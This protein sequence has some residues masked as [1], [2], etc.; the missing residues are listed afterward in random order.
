[1]AAYFGVTPKNS[2]ALVFHV[3]SYSTAQRYRLQN[4]GRVRRLI[5]HHVSVKFALYERTTRM[6]YALDEKSSS[7][8]ETCALILL[9][10]AFCQRRFHPVILSLAQASH[11]IVFPTHSLLSA[12]ICDRSAFIGG[13]RSSQAGQGLRAFPEGR[14]GAPPD[15]RREQ[16]AGR[17][18]RQYHD[19]SCVRKC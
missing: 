7:F 19:S 6:S 15:G 11:T 8:S 9:H 3:L 14:F 1:M 16:P 4:D 13:T 18:M 12:P 17:V 10:L 2:D 5:N